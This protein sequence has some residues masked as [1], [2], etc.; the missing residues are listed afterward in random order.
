MFGLHNHRGSCWVNAALQA[1]FRIPDVQTRYNQN[2]F[3]KASLVDQCMCTIWKTRGEH[4]LR[5]FF[6][7][8]RTDTMPAGMD[9]GDS[10]ELIQYLCDKLPLLDELCR[11]KVAYSIE[12]NACKKKSITYDS[13]IE[14]TL[15]SVN[16]T[17]VPLSSCIKQTT[18]PYIINEW[19]CE[20][21]HKKGGM[22]QQ[23]I[24]SFPRC[25]VFHA[26]LANTTID[27]SSI[28]VL[29]KQTYALASIVC[30][31]GGHWW[32]Y[33]RDMPPGSAWHTLNDTHV[34][35]H[36]SKQFPVSP[37]MRMLFYYRLDE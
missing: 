12:C 5:D 21:C 15:D 7:A 27:Y 23:L 31:N 32:A 18:D 30:F 19:E 22:R 24:G 10:H 2:V 14:F 17:H 16:G 3:D 20:S 4:G 9:I 25:M 6:E 29:N 36:T 34:T 37:H 13:V 28:V 8:V 33:G 35:E 11:F 1:V 26:P